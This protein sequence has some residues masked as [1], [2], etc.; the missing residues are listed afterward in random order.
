METFQHLMTTGKKKKKKSFLQF[1]VEKNTSGKPL[2]HTKAHPNPF[3][4]LTVQ[5][6]T[7]LL[8]SCETD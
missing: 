8:N 5:M 4:V 2:M 3:L 6:P 1:M 7:K